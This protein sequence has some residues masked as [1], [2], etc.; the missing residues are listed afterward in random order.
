M[1]RL[2]QWFRRTRPAAPDA[3]DPDLWAIFRGADDQPDHELLQA[4]EELRHRLQAQPP[5]DPNPEFQARLRASLMREARATRE[6]RARPRRLARPRL[7][8]WGIAGAAVVAVV[9]ASALALPLHKGE[10]Q[11]QAA[12]AGHHQLPVTQAI[13][14]SFNRPM[15]ES[16]VV[17][18]LTIKPAVS[19]QANWPNPKTLVLSP[20]HGLAPNVGYVVTISQPATRA[21]DGA[22]AAAAIVIPFGTSSA[23]STPQG[24]IPTVVSVTHVAVTQGVTSL[25]YLP[26]GALLVLSSGV[27][28]TLPSS[29]PT[30]SPSGPP[31]PAANT[32]STTG[33]AFGTLYVLSPALTAVATNA[34]GAVA[35]PDSQEIAYWTPAGNGALSLEVVAA[36]GRG[37]P[38]TLAT[39]AESNPGLAW[40]DNGDLLY[41]AA[42]QLR[43]VSLDGQVTTVDPGVQVDPSGFFSLSPSAQALFALPAGVPT[44]YSLPSGTATVLTDLVG[45]PA[46]SSSGSELAYVSTGGGGQAIESTSDLGATSTALLTAPAGVQLSDLSFDPTGTYLAYTST[47]PGR[48]SQ[49]DALDV[50]S[51]V[52]GTLSSVTS[53]SDPVWAST[54]DQLSALASISGTDSQSVDTLLLVGGPPPTSSANSAAAAALSTASSLAQ[55]QV[56]GG[57]S[58]LGAITALLAPGTT[59]PPSLLLPDKFDRFYAVSTTATGPGATSYS[60]ELRLVRDATSSLEPAFLPEMVNVQTAGTSTLITNISPG[61]LTPIPTGPLVL[62]VASTSSHTGTTVFSIQ[63]DSDLNPLTVGSQ[64]IGISVGGQL[65]SGAQYYYAALT[66]TETVTVIALPAGAVTVTV[67][68]P[69]ADINNTPIQSSYQVVLQPQT[70][71][72][73]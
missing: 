38:Q 73:G 26:D 1:A 59:L 39:S 11:V 2:P 27:P 18:G 17:Q 53:V 65:V 29:T 15:D 47:A 37:T 13:R 36:D 72:A 30:P 6:S 48:Q 32:P 51:K 62:S 7:A 54:G 10:V 22:Q 63:F 56:A 8:T 69:L 45:K 52:S 44:V 25:S 14:I 4:A 31:T 12:V 3:V 40:L 35:S 43:E 71:T 42:G 19:Y 23:P 28:L 9:V 41:A 68:P 58:A 5:P 46:W 20:V 16:A 70:A 66:R 64:S 24:Q 55:L 49:L 34:L 33:P 50:H 57:P 21:Q 60:V 67:A 61:L